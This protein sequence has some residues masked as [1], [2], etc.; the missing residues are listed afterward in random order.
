MPTPPTSRL[1]TALRLLLAAL[2]LLVLTAAFLFV[3]S[4]L[5]AA[6]TTTMTLEP[7]AGQVG[8]MVVPVLAQFHPATEQPAPDP[9]PTQEPTPTEPTATP[10]APEPA[11]AP[12][13]QPGQDATE[14]GPYPN[15]DGRVPS[16]KPGPPPEPAPPAPCL[17]LC[18][19]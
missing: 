16:T 18:A 19:P 15:D 14:D 7:A 3:G 2:F 8:I 6:P 10:P 5:P 4:R 12:T 13:P 9:V 1:S 17:P 11:P